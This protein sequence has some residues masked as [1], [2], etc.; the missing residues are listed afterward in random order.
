MRLLASL[1]TAIGVS[2]LMAVVLGIR[3]G[4]PRRRSS[5]GRSQWLIQAGLA[6]S[7][8]QFWMASFFASGVSFLFLTVLTGVWTVA[9]PPALV[10]AL[11][12]RLYFGRVR[13]RRLADV[14]RAWPDGL[15]DLVASISAGASLQRA[16]SQL[17][18]TGPAPLR[19]AFARFS[20]LSA[21]LGMVPAL[22]VIKEEL[23]D[24]TSDRVI[25]VLILAH[26]R[27][28]Q[29]VPVILRELAEAT[30]RDI[31]MLEE[32]AT[33]SLEQKI[34]ARAV[35]ALP[36]LVL[37]AITL[38]DGAFRQ[39][40][41]GPGGLVVVLIGAVLSAAGIWL[42]TVLGRDPIEPRVLTAGAEVRK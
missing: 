26:E 4:R 20:F 39:F 31:W 14:Q 29:I 9:L 23:A 30:T 37:V 21:S 34:N 32:I 38:S 19:T 3:V 24:P 41:A 7:P 40:Y 33:Q 6:I 1:V 2:L 22:E 15:R 42:V 13:D 17:A 16:V 10:V 5:S 28:G 18:E 11:L 8:R 27:G 12:P 36:W 35:F 25:E